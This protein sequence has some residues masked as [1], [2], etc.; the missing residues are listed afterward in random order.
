MFNL[1]Y[2]NKKKQGDVGMG[3][4]IGWFAANGYTVSIPLTDS[5]D[6]DLIVDDCINIKRVQVKTTRYKQPS[7]NYEVALRTSGGNRSGIGKVKLFDSSKNDLLFVVTEDERLY[8]IPT[9]QIDSTST[10][11]LGSRYNNFEVKFMG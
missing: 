3:I 2:D 7:G 9:D 1:N 6:Y 11:C 8:L 10:I 4:A 5:Q